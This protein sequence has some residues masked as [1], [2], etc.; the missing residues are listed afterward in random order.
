MKTLNEYAQEQMFINGQF[1]RLSKL[2]SYWNEK[3]EYQKEYDELWPQLV[4]ASGEAETANGEAIRCASRLYYE[5]YN[6]GNF[7]ARTER[8]FEDENSDE[9]F[10]VEI[11]DY[12][13]EMLKYLRQYIFDAE[14]NGYISKYLREFAIEC[15]YSIERTILDDLGFDHSYA[16]AYDY[17]ADIINL[18]AIEIPNKTR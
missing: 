18:C 9:G 6:N 3:G 1:L 13:D 17:L 5:Y 2:A 10:E 15:I 7:N 11:D 16:I 8:Y 4:P 12:Y 14:E